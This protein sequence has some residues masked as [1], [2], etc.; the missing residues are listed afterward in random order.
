MKKKQR[1]MLAV[2]YR[3]PAEQSAAE[4]GRRGCE[5]L[6]WERESWSLGPFGPSVAQAEAFFFRK[7]NHRDSLSVVKHQKKKKKEREYA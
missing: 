6:D 3:R 4:F 5:G 1:K 7:K 2:A